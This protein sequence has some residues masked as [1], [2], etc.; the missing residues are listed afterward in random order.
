MKN[1]LTVMEGIR[2]GIMEGQ[3]ARDFRN[4][5]KGHMDITNVGVVW[6]SRGGK[7]GWLGWGVVVGEKC[8]QLYLNNNKK[9]HCKIKII[10]H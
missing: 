5:Y 9:S 10:R 3:G 2:E 7:W 8:R 1:S 6:W 4:S